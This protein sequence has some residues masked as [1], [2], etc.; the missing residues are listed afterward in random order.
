MAMKISEKIDLEP[1]RDADGK[2]SDDGVD[3]IFRRLDELIR[4]AVRRALAG[5]KGDHDGSKAENEQNRH[6][7]PT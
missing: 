1:F 4:N 7:T 2:F 3:A 6:R 5:G